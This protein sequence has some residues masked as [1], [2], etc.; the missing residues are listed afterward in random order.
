MAKVTEDVRFRKV[1]SLQGR[2]KDEALKQHLNEND[3]VVVRTTIGSLP[4]YEIEKVSGDPIQFLF[5]LGKKLV[6]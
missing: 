1:N 2:A 6:K 5:N 3:L 4:E